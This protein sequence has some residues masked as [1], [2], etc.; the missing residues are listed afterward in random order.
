M[1][2]QYDLPADHVVQGEMGNN[3]TDVAALT[4]MRLKKVPNCCVS[5]STRGR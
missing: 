2:G 1:F 4:W 3:P 5:S